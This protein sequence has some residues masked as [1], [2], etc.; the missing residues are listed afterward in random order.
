MRLLEES[1]SF[2]NIGDRECRMRNRTAMIAAATL[3][4]AGTLEVGAARQNVVK[5]PQEPKLQIDTRQT[6]R[7]V[8]PYGSEPRHPVQC[9]GRR[10]RV[11]AVQ[12]TKTVL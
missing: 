8:S 10:F 3:F 11:P 2:T 7:R 4:L 6:A 5:V 12:Q 1:R 9:S